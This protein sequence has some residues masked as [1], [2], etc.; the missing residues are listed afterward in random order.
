VY[1]EACIDGRVVQVAPKLFVAGIGWS[2]ENFYDLPTSYDMKQ[3]CASVLKDALVKMSAG[4]QSII[5]THYPPWIDEVYGKVATYE[6]V[7]GWMYDCVREVAEAI[8]PLAVLSGHVHQLFGASAMWEGTLL[9]HPG[10]V[11][12]ILTVDPE[13]RTAFYSFP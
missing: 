7:E 3:I 2:G 10:S 4:D 6:L 11:P 12:G 9:V 8:R 13:A 1:G 5:L